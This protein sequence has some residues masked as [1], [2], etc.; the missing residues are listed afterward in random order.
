M[1]YQAE[2]SKLD[3]FALIN[4]RGEEE[5]VTRFESALS[6]MFPRTAHT[7][8][9][10][11]NVAVLSLAP[12][13]WWVRT[14]IQNE[15]ETFEALFQAGSTEHAAVTIV[16]DHFCGFSVNGPEALLVL[17]QGV[18]LDLRNLHTGQCTR[19]GFARCGATFH[20]VDYARHYDLF[21]ESSYGDYVT[22]W[23]ARARGP[24]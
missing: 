3:N 15:R 5:A 7:T 9:A 16:T 10:K 11:D 24:E 6:L 13:H 23:L 1:S 20:V 22:D 14:S 4:L 18:S 2:I 8:A 12:D 19:G 21:V 17:R